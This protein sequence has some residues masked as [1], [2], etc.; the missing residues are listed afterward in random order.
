MALATLTRVPQPL[1]LEDLE[2]RS[3]AWRKSIREE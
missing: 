1:G 2:K 3:L